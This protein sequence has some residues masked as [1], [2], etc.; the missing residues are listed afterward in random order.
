MPKNYFFVR[1]EE[2]EVKK[3]NFKRKKGKEAEW[4][5]RKIMIAEIFFFQ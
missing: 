5:S 2:K 4:A 1:K 3:R